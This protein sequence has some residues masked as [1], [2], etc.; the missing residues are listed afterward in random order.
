MK[1]HTMTQHSCLHLRQAHWL[2]CWMLFCKLNLTMLSAC[3]VERAAEGERAQDLQQHLARTIE[4][5][6]SLCRRVYA[7]SGTS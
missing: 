4:K 7:I 2:T 1:C 5:H 6:R 3:A